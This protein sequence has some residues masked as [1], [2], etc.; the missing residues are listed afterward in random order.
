LF[1]FFKNLWIPRFIRVAVT[2]AEGWWFDRKRGVRTAG[3]VPLE[4]LTLA[5]TGRSGFDYLPIRPL[6]A[7]QAL[8]RLP[9]QNHA[10]YTFVD[11]GSGK[12]RM[13]LAAAEYPFRKIQG[14]EFALQL[15]REAEQNIS[16]Y[17]YAG[18]RCKDVESI[19][20]D[21]TECVFPQGNL[22]VYLYNPFGPEVLSQVLTNLERALTELPRSVI[23]ILVNPEF[24]PVI[25][26][27]PFLRLH[28]ETRHFRI[29]RSTNAG[30]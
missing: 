18:Q 26:A 23:V 28:L 17:R 3:Y 5:G 25:D 19:H 29:Y 10:E 20:L 30:G 12:G 21:A 2:R 9:I 15:H 27:M 22:V 8:A 13:L 16:R 11:L 7:R 24:A 14:I 6:V 4:G 1:E